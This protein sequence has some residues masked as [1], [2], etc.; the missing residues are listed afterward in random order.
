L[1]DIYATWVPR[2]RILTTNLWSSELSKLTA[3]A[4]LAQRVSSINAISALCEATGADVDEVANAIGADSRIGPKFLK[5]SVG[6]GGSCFQKDI[7]NLV[8]LCEHFGI[9]EVASYW[10]QVVK[11]NNHQRSRFAERIVR[12][13]FNTVSDKQIGVWG[14]AFKK[15]TNDTRE[16]AAIYVCRDLLREHARLLIY[17]PQVTEQQIRRDL[18][19]ALR[20]P[21][22][23]KLRPDD[24]A[25]LEKNVKVVSSAEE[26]ACD[27]HA[28]AVLT[29]WDEFAE[30]DFAEVRRHMPSPAFIFDGRN[31]LDHAMLRQQGFELHAIGKPK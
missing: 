11:M 22:T 13:M 30:V 18:K 12:T 7:L 15:D 19:Q 20:N 24:K 5:A 31:L 2:D 14:F 8:Y 23:G 9:P 25:A 29:E 28:V 21:E 27:S 16:S 6:F 17:D 3:N 4:F 1:V 10:E 26:A